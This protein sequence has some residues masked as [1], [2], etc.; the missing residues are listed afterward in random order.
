MEFTAQFETL[1]EVPV[2]YVTQDLELN[3]KLQET[4]TALQESISE[5]GSLG[6]LIKLLYKEAM[7][8]TVATK[9]LITQ[10]PSPAYQPIGLPRNA[11]TISLSEQAGY[12][13]Y[14]MKF[15]GFATRK[16]TERLHNTKEHRDS[17]KKTVTENTVKLEVKRTGEIKMPEI[18]GV[19]EMKRSVETAAPPTPPATPPKQNTG[20]TARSPTKK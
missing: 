9:E 16:T 2:D 14:C 5:N 7:V 17:L 18:A 11:D 20:N 4:R 15:H 1:F 12:V 10:I 13:M 8:E 19:K 3:T 6:E